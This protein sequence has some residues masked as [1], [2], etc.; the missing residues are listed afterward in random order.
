MAS[1]AES[2]AVTSACRL[3]V[4][5]EIVAAQHRKVAHGAEKMLNWRSKVRSKEVDRYKVCV[6]RTTLTLEGDILSPVDTPMDALSSPGPE[7]PASLSARS[8]G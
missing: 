8:V 6:G 3:K 1:V 4:S 5:S 7:G 2:L